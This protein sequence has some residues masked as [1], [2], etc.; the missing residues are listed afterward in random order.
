MFENKKNRYADGR[1]LAGLDENII[2]NNLSIWK[3]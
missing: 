3:Q 1:D 2:Y